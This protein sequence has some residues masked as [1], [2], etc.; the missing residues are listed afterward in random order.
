MIGERISQDNEYWCNFLL[1]LTIVDYLFAP[2]LSPDCTSYIK[3]L[4]DDHHQAWLELYPSC[5]VT[6]KMHYMIHYPECIER[7]M[8]MY[9]VR[10]VDVWLT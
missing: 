7:Y 4:I 2:V 6:P 1:L 8:N 3:A 10:V 5:N 9:N